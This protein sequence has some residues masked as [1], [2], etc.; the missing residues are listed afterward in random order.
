MADINVLLTV[1][2]NAGQLAELRGLSRSLNVRSHPVAQG[3]Q[4]PDGEWGDVQV[5]YTFRSLPTPELAPA[6]RWIQFHL[7]GVEEHLSAPILQ[8]PNLQATTL[9]GANAPQVAEHALALM[10]ALGH[11]LPRILAD[12]TERKWPTR[13]SESHLPSELIGSTVGIVGYGSVGQRLARLLAS[14]GVTV[15]ASKRDIVSSPRPDEFQVDGQGDPNGEFVRRLYPAQALRTMFKECD[16]VVVTV[17]LTPQTRGLI[18]ARQLAGMKPS[19]FLV[20]VSR[21]GVVDHDALLA[22][23]QKKQLA[24]AGLDVFHDEPLPAD[25][26]LWEQPNVIISPHVAG[27]SPHYI[28][29]AFTL[30]KENLRRYV[31]GE[32]LLNRIDLERGY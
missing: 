23:L 8:Q 27:L 14:F 13:R 12:Q 15:L 18:G 7:A 1:E 30:F 24:G 5:L 22:A 28:E 21:G 32:P 10:L 31:A 20:D 11:R 9:S 3:Q 25:S 26:P 6:L 16:F 17:P 19:A 2:F 4:L 29:R